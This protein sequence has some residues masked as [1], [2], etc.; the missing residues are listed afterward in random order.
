M[1]DNGSG[2]KAESLPFVFDR[3]Y[4]SDGQEEHYQ[5]GS[6]IGLALVKELVQLHHGTITVNSTPSKETSSSIAF[7]KGRAHLTD[8]QVIQHAKNPQDTP[9]NWEV[10]S[11]AVSTAPDINLQ[12]PLK[13]Q[14]CVLVV[15]DHPDVME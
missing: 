1:R 14:A 9:L 11:T 3:F 2:I 15:E 7:K 6:G 8:D 10:K 5:K 12:T 13:N 4:Q